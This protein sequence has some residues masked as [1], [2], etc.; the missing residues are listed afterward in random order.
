MCDRDEWLNG[1]ALPAETNGDPAGCEGL[2]ALGLARRLA[3]TPIVLRRRGESVTC[4]GMSD[5]SVCMTGIM[6]RTNQVAARQ[7][8]ANHRETERHNQQ[9]PNVHNQ[10]YSA[11]E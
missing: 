1:L 3:G 5:G 8:D 6:L 2:T 9:S 11:V 10:T 4:G 7:R